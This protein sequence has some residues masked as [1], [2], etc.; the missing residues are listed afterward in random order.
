MVCRHREYL[1]GSFSPRSGLFFYN[2]P[3]TEK[4]DFF[5]GP[6]VMLL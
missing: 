6:S 3:Q 4:L 1:S 2:A 5:A